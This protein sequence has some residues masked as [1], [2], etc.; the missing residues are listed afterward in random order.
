MFTLELGDPLAHRALQALLRAEATVRKR[1]AL[2]LEREGVTGA[3]FS[4]LVVLTTAGGSLELKTLRRRL[5]WSKANAT[6]VTSTLASRGFVS[7]RRDP[8]DRRVVVVGLEPSGRALVE[9]LFPAHSERV[10]AAF[11]NLDESEKR[12]FSE[13]CRKLAA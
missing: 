5:G 9:R 3:G 8:S 6:E 7:R 1:L 11:R 13:L 10:T 4:V 2:E 12:T